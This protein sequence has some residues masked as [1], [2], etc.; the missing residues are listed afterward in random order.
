[1]DIYNLILNR[2][3]DKEFEI[4]ENLDVEKI[5]ATLLKSSVYHVV[6]KKLHYRVQMDILNSFL[7]DIKSVL[8]ENQI[9][10]NNSYLLLC[11]DTKIDY[12]TFFIIERDTKA[13][14]KYVIVNENDLNR[15]PFLDNL[16]EDKVSLNIDYI[17]EENIYL[18]E[19]S[20]FMNEKQGQQYKLK[21][22]EISEGVER[23]LHIME[24]EYGD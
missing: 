11:F 9:N 3:E 13:L 10:I 2:L 20:S 24:G 15:I 7:F 22:S 17:A 14:R 4:V 12:E 6:I 21:P 18:T 5:G 16:N 8:M 1:M 19:L 23:I